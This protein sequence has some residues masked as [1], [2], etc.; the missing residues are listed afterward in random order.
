MFSGQEDFEENMYDILGISK[1][2]RPGGGESGGKKK[3]PKNEM[4]KS[5]MKKYFPDMYNDIYG[6]TDEV[7]Q[8]MK[9]MR[10]EILDSMNE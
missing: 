8:E 3:S 1:S 5:D 10:Q 7:E 2:Y 6:G 9:K 4:S